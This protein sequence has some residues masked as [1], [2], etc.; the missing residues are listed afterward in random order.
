MKMPKHLFPGIMKL[1]KIAVF[2]LAFSSTVKQT[3]PHYKPELD[4]GWVQLASM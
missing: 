4:V 1:H 2:Y 3:K